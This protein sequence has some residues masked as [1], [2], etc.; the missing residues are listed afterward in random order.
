[1]ARETGQAW[2]HPEHGSYL[3][4]AVQLLGLPKQRYAEVVYLY[5]LGWSWA[6]IGSFLDIAPNTARNYMQAIRTWVGAKCAF[7][8]VRIGYERLCVHLWPS[9]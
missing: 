9:T 5:L 1:V 6:Q 8:V 2:R 3:P 7:E 4:H